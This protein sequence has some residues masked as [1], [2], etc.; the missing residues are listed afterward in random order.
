[1]DRIKKL[2]IK[3]ADGTF[4]DYI[5]VGTDALYVDLD[6][7][8]NVQDAIDDIKN[9]SAKYYDTVAAMKADENLRIGDM[10]VT[11]GYYEV[12]DGIGQ[13]YFI[14]QRVE[15]DD[16]SNKEIIILST[17][18]IAQKINEGSNIYKHKIW[19]ANLWLEGLSS[20]ESIRNLLQKVKDA[21]MNTIYL[22]CYHRMTDDTNFTIVVPDSTIR[23]TIE[24]AQEMNFDNIMI[25]PHIYNHSLLT[26][27]SASDFLDLWYTRIAQLVTIS[28]EYNLPKIAVGNELVEI[29]IHNYNKWKRIIDYVKDQGMLATYTFQT[30]K[31]FF[32]CSFTDELDTIEINHYPPI[33]DH[34]ENLTFDKAKKI[35]G[36]TSFFEETSTFERIKKIAQGRPIIISEFGIQSNVDALFNPP[37]FEFETEAY[38]QNIQALYYDVMLNVFGG[39]NEICNGMIVW[40]CEKGSVSSTYSGF[41][42]LRNPKT[43]EILNKYNFLGGNLYE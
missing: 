37:A 40:C 1:M 21:K 13:K 29:S 8:D 22:A 7:G 32:R 33:Y 15:S 24:I 12:N 14:R 11:K 26:D 39:N 20:D 4:S 10:A 36:N 43:I 19:G 42:P 31:E 5:P 16:E 6:N 25:K 38:N 3:K 18:L 28:K 27:E 34:Y 17:S 2:K 35:L 30:T 23:R 41:N 9:K